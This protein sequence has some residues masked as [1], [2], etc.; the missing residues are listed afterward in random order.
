MI[1]QCVTRLQKGTRSVENSKQM[2]YEQHG[3]LTDHGWRHRTGFAI[4][5]VP[6]WGCLDDIGS[7]RMAKR[8]RMRWSPKGV[9]RVTV[10]GSLSLMTDRTVPEYHG[11]MGRMAKLK[12]AHETESASKITWIS[13]V[14]DA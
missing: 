2:S 11:L 13:N 8:H 5:F 12:R 14:N 3:Y 1:P 10:S 4:S 7:T 9:H 6:R